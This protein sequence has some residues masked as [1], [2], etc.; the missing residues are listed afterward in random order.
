MDAARVGSGRN[1]GVVVLAVDFCA[2]T[3]RLLVKQ[4]RLFLAWGRKPI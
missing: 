2:R 3:S 1:L 4:L